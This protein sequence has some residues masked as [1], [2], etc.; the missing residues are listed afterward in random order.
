MPCAHTFLQKNPGDQEMRQV[1]E[2]YKSQ[3]DLNGFL[4]DHEE[5][6]HEVRRVTAGYSQTVK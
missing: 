6:P 4:T 1:M 5:K 2:E 3:Y